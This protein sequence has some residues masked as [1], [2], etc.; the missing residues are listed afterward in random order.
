[1]IQTKTAVII[2]SIAMAL[3]LLWPI[4]ENWKQTPTDNFPLSYYPMFS[5]KRDPHYTVN[6][7]VGYDSAHNRH[8][9]PYKYI[10]AGGLNQSRRQLNKNINRKKYNKVANSVVK[11]I[12]RSKQSPY[13]EIREIHLVQGTYELDNY[14]AEEPTVADEKILHVK[15]IER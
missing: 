2:F 13:K 15:K 4:A 5:A 7:V 1:M 3:A 6:Y 12:K 8:I 10:G 14:F 11:R 9:I